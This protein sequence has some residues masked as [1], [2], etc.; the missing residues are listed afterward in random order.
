[1]YIHIY[2]Y[3]YS[4]RLYTLFAPP[5]PRFPPSGRAIYVLL[6]LLLLLLLLLLITVN[7]TIFIITISQY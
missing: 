6:F 5:E 7:F 4:Y 2:I 3:I 1:M